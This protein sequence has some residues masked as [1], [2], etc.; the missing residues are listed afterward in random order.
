MGR[1]QGSPLPRTHT[2]VH[3][4]HDHNRQ[5]MR[6]HGFDYTS[7]GTYFVTICI[8]GRHPLLGAFQNQHLKLSPAGLM[9]ARGWEAL[10]QRFDYLSVRSYVVMPNHVHGLLVLARDAATLEPTDWVFAAP[11]NTSY[12]RPLA[13]GTAPGSLGRIIQAFK[14]L[15]THAY[16]QGVRSSSWPP[17][18]ERLWQRGYHDRVVRDME[19]LAAIDEYI[20]LNPVQWTQHP[21]HL[22]SDT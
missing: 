19:E 14:S 4:P 17:F 20:R 3:S 15:T 18:A 22:Q 8:Q 16:M 5:S 10:P 12:G 7:A 1:T 13:T 2:M 11:I 6:W 21:Y 9:V